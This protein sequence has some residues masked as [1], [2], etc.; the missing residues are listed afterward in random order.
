MVFF[1]GLAGTIA[2]AVGIRMAHDV[3]WIKF[4]DNLHWTSGTLAAAVLSWHGWQRARRTAHAPCLFWFALGFSG[5]AVGQI[6][7][8][9]QTFLAYGEFPSPSD[10]FYLWLGPSICVGLLQEI[11]RNSTST[12]YLAARLDIGSLSIASVTLV[13]ALYLP[14]RGDLEPLALAVLVAYP[15]SLLTAS[16][17]GMIMVPILR[18]R[19]TLSIWLFLP[20][21]GVTAWSW[22]HW[23]LMALNGVTVDGAWFNVSFSFAILLAGLAAAGWRL[24]SSDEPRWDRV[25]EG[26]LRSLPLVSVLVASGAVI[27][28]ATHPSLP[29]ITGQATMAGSFAVIVLAMVRQALLLNERDQLLVAQEEVLRGKSLLQ[30]VIDTAPIRVFWKDRQSRYLGCNQAFAMDAGLACPEDI[31]GRVDQELGWHAEAKLYQADDQAVMS[32]GQGKLNYEER[33]TTSDGR[34]IWLR[35]SKVPLRDNTGHI[36]GVLGIYDDITEQKRAEEAL[37]TWEERLRVSQAYGGVGVWENDL[38]NNRQ[39]WSESICSLLGFPYTEEPR[40]ESFIQAVLPED[41]ERVAEANRR[42][43]EENQPYDVDYRIQTGTGEVRWMHS[44]GQVEHDANG[45]PVRMRG[46]VQDITT[47]KHQEEKLRLAQQ[48]YEHS[49]ESMLV[50]EADGTILAVNPAFTHVTGYT[51]EEVL[52]QNPRILSSGKHDTGFYQ[53][54]W[55]SLITTGTWE[56]EIWN[57][58]KNGELYVERLFINTV[59]RDDGT[60]WRRVGLFSDIT[61]QKTNEELLWKQANLDPLTGL[62]NRRMFQDQLAREMK[63]SQRAGVPLGLLFLDMDRFKDVNDTLGHETGDEL[64]KEAAA[65][66]TCC[67]RATDTVARLGGDEFTVILSEVENP[68]TLDRICR[69]ILERLSQ[70]FHLRNEVAYVS[71][72]IGITL[73]PS[74]AT[75]I[76]QLIKNA[77]Q[78]MYAAK[79]QGR[80]RASYFTPALQVAAEHRL[81]I[82]NDLRLALSRQQLEVHYQP[83][84]ELSTGSVHKAEALVRWKHPEKG[85][86]PPSEFIPVAEDTGLIHELGDWVFREAMN[87]VM[88]WRETI[89]PHFQISVNKSP[90]QIR[91]PQ[92]GRGHWSVLMK[93]LGLP[94]ES[95]VVEITEGLLLESQESIRQKLLGFHE[96]GIQVAIDDFGIG[97]SA[98]SYLKKFEIDYLKI[99]QSFIRNLPHD[100][101]DLALCEAIVVMAH[102]LGLK[103]IAEGVETTQQRDQL[104]AIDCDYAQGYLFAKPMPAEEFERRLAGYG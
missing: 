95:L 86:I 77:D 72:S 69:D 73:Y 64:L 37:R 5:Y 75:E 76:D 16:A 80:N 103:V 34:L 68:E 17:I 92:A 97:Y 32:S 29:A 74:D 51:A 61:Q 24:E 66:L 96:A 36:L 2:G 25:C 87:H 38:L 30:V 71:A 55:D 81:R 21:L 46:I 9:I 102:K 27:A 57:R 13:L 23:N 70:P 47:R 79:A 1:L 98:L 10:L 84:V 49:S 45:S 4:F 31:I 56:G 52:G 26:I 54:I 78:A 94:G 83:I 28:T 82:A 8:D 3:S 99:D 62:P 44:A 42:H 19:S 59:Y 50:T 22:M 12:Q 18:L 89:H 67:V 6:V 15:A 60:P 88:P 91:N 35:T 14:K 65:R 33:L 58:R 104:K 41:R 100:S 63:K 7:W 48:V 93:S 39:Y 11:R 101:S 20:S 40:W 53:A 90:V 85:Y 43:I